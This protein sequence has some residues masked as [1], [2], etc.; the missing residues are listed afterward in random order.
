MKIKYLFWIVLLLSCSTSMQVG[1]RTTQKKCK[2]KIHAVLESRASLLLE[3]KGGTFTLDHDKI[4]APED[5]RTKKWNFIYGEVFAFEA[6]DAKYFDYAQSLLDIEG[7]IKDSECLI[8]VEDFNSYFKRPTKIVRQIDE[9]IYY[10]M[11]NSNI[12]PECYRENVMENERYENCRF[13]MVI[14]D[15][16]EKFKSINTVLFAYR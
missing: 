2:S 8:T 12:Y 14:F 16:E 15:L 13:F 1:E 7:E 3:T 4:T 6:I 9:I 10:Y 11:M 5:W